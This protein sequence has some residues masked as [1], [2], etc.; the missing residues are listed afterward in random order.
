MTAHEDWM[1]EEDWEA[2]RARSAAEG[3]RPEHPEL[4]ED[5]EDTC[6]RP[7][8]LDDETLA[9]MDAKA[10]ADAAIEAAGVAR[11]IAAGFGYGYAHMTGMGPLPGTH[12]GPAAAFGQGMVLDEAPATTVLALMADQATGIDPAAS[13][14]D[15]TTGAG[16]A[17]GAGED[18]RPFTGVSDDELLGL[19]SARGRI[20]AR[21][22]W[23]ALMVVAEFIRR[24]PAPGCRAEGPAR[25]PACWSEHAGS[26]LAL[27]LGGL[28]LS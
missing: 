12:S 14:A 20:E 24:R 28:P 8:D 10:E 22:A 18:S 4:R 11:G 17:G 7:A 5:P 19:L 25:M 16:S 23:E 15:G 9:A 1:S 6:S 21:Q 3:P 26:E 2:S 13:D 27:Q